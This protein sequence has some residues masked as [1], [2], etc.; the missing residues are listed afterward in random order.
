MN[1][2]DAHETRELIL[3][4]TIEQNPDVTQ[5]TLADKLDVA[6]GTVNW[7]IK[8]LVEKGFIKLKRA[9]RKKLRYIITPEGLAFRA[10][11]TVNYVENSMN[12]FRRTRRKTLELLADIRAEGYESIRILGNGDLV[13]V[14]RLT[15]LEQGVGVDG[16]PAAPALEIRGWRVYRSEKELQP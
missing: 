16:D 3:L 2:D 12:L 10:Q 9:E 8:R 14:I 5:V 7:H 4:E 11:L 1:L 15:C 13:D 6:V